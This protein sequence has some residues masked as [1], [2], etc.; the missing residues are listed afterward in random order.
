M[1]LL[2]IQ[3]ENA[4]KS[5]SAQAGPDPSIGTNWGDDGVNVGSWYKDPGS[6]LWASGPRNV[7]EDPNQYKFELLCLIGENDFDV[8]CLTRTFKCTAGENGRPV[9]WFE[10]S[11]SLKVPKWELIP[12]EFCV[13]SEKP[14]DVLEDIAANIQEQFRK[15]PISAGSVAAQPSPHTL[16]GAETNF[17]VEASPQDFDVTMFGQK[18]HVKA[19]PIEYKWKYGDGA[20]RGPGPFAGGPLPESR[21]GETTNTSHVYAQTGDYSVVVTTYFQGTYSVNGGPSLPIPGTGE[22]TSQP[23]Q[24]SVWRSVTRNYA[25]N[26]IENPQGAGC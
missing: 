25:D 21:W 1:L 12:G 14:S 6:G 5:P 26:C 23:L 16:R 22:F 3:V 8:G 10:S 15:L 13:Y 18:V 9:Q 20:T 2:L 19:A 24:I 4:V 17:Y 7:P 11:K